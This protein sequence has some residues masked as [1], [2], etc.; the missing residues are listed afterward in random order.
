M[1]STTTPYHTLQTQRAD[2]AEAAL[3][4]AMRARADSAN[5]ARDLQA[6]LNSL[7]TPHKDLATTARANRTLYSPQETPRS[8]TGVLTNASDG[9]VTPV[10]S[11]WEVRH[12]HATSSLGGGDSVRAHAKGSLWGEAVCRADVRSKHVRD[13]IA[14][15]TQSMQS[16]R[17]GDAAASRTASKSS[18][19][20]HE[21]PSLDTSGMQDVLFV[22][23]DSS[24]RADEDSIDGGAAGV[25]E[26]TAHLQV[27]IAAHRR[28]KGLPQHEMQKVCSR[29]CVCVHN[30]HVPLMCFYGTKERLV[31]VQRGA[32]FPPTAPEPVGT[33]DLN[34]HTHHDV[35]RWSTTTCCLRP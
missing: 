10:Q 4:T 30:V 17:D 35:C 25:S 8:Y 31:T 5:V 21:G 14:A 33:E 20:S 2:T 28:C 26:T 22:A 11:S 7:T 1:L 9:K 13:A 23:A 19:S 16:E 15:A 34:T 32:I 29:V 24:W 18:S 3:Q 6:R 12:A 27:E